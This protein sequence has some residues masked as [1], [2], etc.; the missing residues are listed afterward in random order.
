M[1]RLLPFF[2]AACGTRNHLPP[3][4]PP[5]GIPELTCGL[6]HW[7]LLWFT[8]DLISSAPNEM[9]TI[10][11]EGYVVLF[12]AFGLDHLPGPVH[13]TEAHTFR[14][15]SQDRGQQIEATGALLLPD[16]RPPAEGW[17]VM[18]LT[19][20]FAGS[21]GPCAPSAG[22][23]EEGI[24]PAL[25]AMYGYAVI[26]PDYI[27][28]DGTARPPAPH[29]PQNAEQTAIGVWDAWR[30]GVELMSDE[31]LVPITDDVVL[32]GA[33]QGGH[34]ALLAERYQSKYARNADLKA[35]VAGTPPMDVRATMNSILSEWSDG[36]PLAVPT[37]MGWSLW[38]EDALSH[39]DLLVPAL[40]DA[41]DAYLADRPEDCGIEIDEPDHVVEAWF[42]P[43]AIAAASTDD[44]SALPGWDCV[45]D[46]HSL[47][48]NP[49]QDTGDTTPTLTIWGEFDTIV[50][51]SVQREAFE[52]LC[53]DG[54][55]PR[56][57]GCE[58]ADHAE[59]NL[60]SLPETL[61]FLQDAR[62][63]ELEAGT[64]AWGEFVRC[65]ATP[66]E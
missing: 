65:E 50:D 16:G 23:L 2:L 21:A 46:A 44:W 1:R 22:R 45:L 30:A 19:H 36:S 62:N 24:E 52:A 11:R 32:W 38:Y 13:G 12:D 61:A 57:L 55:D 9:W 3:I 14:Y 48:T 49:V 31:L 63:G 40:A 53:T 7:N 29:S 6:G 64:C 5:M 4:T 18:L 54:A 56:W 33:S 37:I 15:T 17:P 25:M 42:T 41:M 20:S 28:L 66:E 58:G 27:G 60:W 47:H 39:R 43:E 26:A 34:A 8:G 51:P 59:A 35:V 10:D